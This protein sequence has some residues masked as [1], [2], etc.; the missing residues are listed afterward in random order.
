[1]ISLVFYSAYCTALR[2]RCQA[3]LLFSTKIDMILESGKGKSIPQKIK[4]NFLFF[5]LAILNK[6]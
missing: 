5:L 1:M 4:M 3:V 6:I 2:V